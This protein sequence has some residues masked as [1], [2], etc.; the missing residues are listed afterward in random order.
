M[1]TKKS[2]AV[3]G[4]EGF[5]MSSARSFGVCPR[6]DGSWEG[7]SLAG[8]G[9]TNLGHSPTFSGMSTPGKHSQAHMGLTWPYGE[10]CAV[11]VRCWVGK[12]SQEGKTVPEMY[13]SPQSHNALQCLGKITLSVENQ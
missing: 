13:L 9:G 10:G 3:S 11:S 2:L 7:T 5:Q 4:G 12:V 6:R 8:L 1:A